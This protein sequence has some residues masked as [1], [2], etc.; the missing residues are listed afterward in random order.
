[1]ANDAPFSCMYLVQVGLA[2]LGE[3]RGNFLKALLYFARESRGLHL[4]C[5]V[6]VPV[7]DFAETNGASEHFGECKR[8]FEHQQQ[9]VVLGELVAVDETNGD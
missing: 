9:L 8:V 3:Q 6:V 2:R 7:D 1:M 5:G 4:E